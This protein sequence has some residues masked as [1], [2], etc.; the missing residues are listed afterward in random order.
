MCGISGILSLNN[1]PVSGAQLL[2]MTNALAHRGP[3]G[4]GYLLTNNDEYCSALKRERNSALVISLKNAQH[5]AMGHKRL[6]VTDLSNAAAQPMTEATGRYWLVFNGQIYNHAE[7]RK[8]LEEKGFR[9]KTDHSD[10]EVI[11]NG[12]K[13]WGKACV[14]R[15]NGMWAFCLWD[16]EENTVFLS[17]DRAGKQPLFYAIH[18]N[19]LYFASELNAILTN[20]AI[21]RSLNDFAVYD[22]LTYASV[23]APD[24]IV[25]GVKKL[26]AAHSIFFRPGRDIRPERY[27]DPISNAPLL[28]LSEAQIV[29]DV[30]EK[31]FNATKLRMIADVD[32]GMLLSGGLDS[33]VILACLSRFS[34]KPVRSYTV[35]FENKNKYTNEFEHARRVA[36]VFKAEHNEVVVTQ[37]EFF[38]FLPE[39]AY[40]QDEPIADAAN[41][42]IYFVSKRAQEQ[43]VKVLL[44]GEGSDE[45]FVGYEHWRLIY[46]F[47]RMLRNQPHLS[48]LLGYLH[49][50]SVFRH[51][52]PHYQVWC[53]KVQNGTPVFWSGTELRTE[54][55]KQ[56][57]LSKAF[58][59]RIGNYSSFMP[60]SELYKAVTH[61]REY[62]TLEWMS[63]ND[64]SDRL[65]DQL[66]ARLDRMMMR[67]SVEGRN[68]FLDINLIEYLLK[69]PAHLKVKDR[70]EK[71][72]LKKAFKGILPDEI[73]SR[74]KD[75]FTV[76]V[77][78]L[79]ENEQKRREY[80]EVIRNF[81][82]ATDIFTEEYISRLVLPK[83]TKK[84]WNALNL[85][86]WCEKH[87]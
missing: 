79:F 4:E 49:K 71:Y 14:E 34:D 37:Q 67:H 17:R 25:K 42:P 50:K 7:L 75:S 35:G 87:T 22:Y 36:S 10:T 47:E 9:F 5:I 15:F 19:T 61:N 8:E 30:K 38:D 33:S 81:N 82:K 63:I 64:L 18:N 28:S 45:L 21:D 43:G 41:V 20:R 85:A 23:P 66:L 3:D 6:S 24:T 51:K 26:P 84:M 78:Q 55:E 29:E 80:V 72:L 56:T 40:I 74:P 46:Q 44:S 59:S 69:V 53:E 52:R 27:W 83:N 48:G 68:P 16:S 32:I 65:P 2:S 13:C 31:L 73:L 62:N 70:T 86:L 12:Y 76:P 1:Q 54:A 58:K 60:K 39:M 57:I 11:L 77:K